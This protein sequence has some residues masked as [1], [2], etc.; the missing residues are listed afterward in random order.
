MQDKRPNV[1]FD[2]PVTNGHK[3]RTSPVETELDDKV[4]YHN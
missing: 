3:A 2:K 1:D 4:S